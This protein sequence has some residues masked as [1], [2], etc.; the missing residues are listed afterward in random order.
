MNKDSWM[1]RLRAF[2][3]RNNLSNPR[4]WTGGVW[5]AVA[6]VALLVFVAVV[7]GPAAEPASATVSQASAADTIK[8]ASQRGFV[9]TGVFTLSG[10]EAYKEKQIEEGLS[11]DPPVSFR[12]EKAKD[13]VTVTMTG[14]RNIAYQGTFRPRSGEKIDFEVNGPPLGVRLSNTSASV[15]KHDMLT[16]VFTEQVDIYSLEENMTIAPRTAYTL[17]YDLNKVY[18]EPDVEWIATDNY[19]IKIDAAYVSKAGKEFAETQVLTFKVPAPRTTT[20]P[21]T[22]GGSGSG[23]S[24][25]T[26]TAPPK[27]QVSLQGTDNFVL[28][29]QTP[30]SMHFTASGLKKDMPVLVETYRMESLEKYRTQG[31]VYLDSDIRLAEMEK[32]DTNAFFVKNG[33]TSFEVPSFGEGA[34][35]LSATY[36]L[37]GTDEEVEVRT[38]YLVTPMTVYMQSSARDTV[39][40]LNRSGES[41]PLA[42]Y[43]VTFDGGAEPV[44]VTDADGVL[45]V[46]LKVEGEG[47]EPDKT[48]PP[49]SSFTIRDPEGTLVYYDDA[50]LSR[51]YYHNE[52]YYSYLFLDRTIYKPEDTVSFWGF[53]QP[54]RNNETELPESVT[55]V[56]D[57]GG[58][59]LRVEAEL[60][61]SGVYHGEIAL[62]RIKS[63][64]YAI[65]AELHFPPLV[66]GEAGTRHVLETEYVS[67]K[68]FEK[69]TFVLSSRTDKDFYGPDDTVTVTVNASFYDG[70]PLPF[71]PLEVMYHDLYN[72]TQVDIKDIVTD[73]SGK[74]TFRFPAVAGGAS[75]YEEKSPRTGQYM[76][77][78]ASDGEQVST[79]GAYTHFPSDT[80]VETSIERQ[81]DGRNLEMTVRAYKLNMQSPQ[82]RA[83]FASNPSYYYYGLDNRRLLEIARGEPVDVSLNMG[84]HW[85]Y[86][87]ARKIRHRNTQGSQSLDYIQFEN[88]YSL[89]TGAADPGFK[90]IEDWETNQKRITVETRDGVAVVR[91]LIYLP[92]GG[93]IDF[94]QDVRMY[95][96]LSY[97]DGKENRCEQSLYYPRD[98]YWDYYG[99]AYRE[100]EEPRVIKG[101]SFTIV[102][103]ATGE[104]ITPSADYYR[105]VTMAAG[106]QYSF[107]LLKDG[108]PVE[109]EGRIL[110]T[111]LNDGVYR[112]GVAAGDSFQLPYEVSFGRNARMVA[113]YFDG[114]KPHYIRQ[115]DLEA[116]EASLGVEIEVTPDKDSYRPGDPVNLAVRATDAV[117]NGV[118]GNLCVAVVDESIFALSEQYID[119]LY[120]LYSEIQGIDNSVRQYCST[121]RDEPYVDDN[122]WDGGKGGGDGVE[123][124]DSYRSNF[125]D[126][127]LFLPTTTDA[128]GNGRIQFTLPDN[129]TSWRITAVEVAGD[130][131]A[132]YSKSNIISTLPFFCK[133]VM[134]SKYIEGD[135]ISM[136][137]QGHGTLLEEG[138]DISYT[139]T[140][141]GDGVEETLS[142]D[143]K[144]FEAME[145]NFGK[146][147][148][149]EYTVVARAQYSGYS[150]TVEL[151]LSVIKSNLELVISKTV[152]VAP[153][154]DLSAA[155]YPVTL[156]L[157]DESNEAFFTSINSLM[158]HYCMQANQRM[159]RFVAKRVVRQTVEGG[160]RLPSYIAEGNDY[161]SD[162]QNTDGGIAFYPGDASEPLVT[163][164]VVAIA[165]D[166]FNLKSMAAY[167]RRQLENTSLS[168]KQRAACWLGLAIIEDAT[169]QELLKL[170]EEAKS[171]DDKA[172]LIAGL[173]YLGE[174]EQALALYNEHLAPVMKKMNSSGSTEEKDRDLAAIWIASSL[175]NETDADALSVYFGKASWRYRTLF[176]C[177][178]YVTNYNR[179]VT[180][181]SFTYTVKG[182]SRTVNLGVTGMQTL[183]LNK[184]EMDTLQFSGYTQG[185]RAAAYY[186]GEPT[187][188][189]LEQSENMEISKS[190]RPVS[191]NTYEVTVA[192]H[193]KEN[194]PLGDYDVNDWVPSNAR[195]YGHDDTHTSGGETVYFD[196]TEEGQ[197]L[198]VSFYNGVQKDRTIQ[199]KYR[200]RQTYQSEAVLDTT[201]MIHG[202]SGENCNTEKGVFEPTPTGERVPP[203]KAE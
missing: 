65:Q 91:D 165:K 61:P 103:T 44:G 164:Y 169:P 137:V 115:L 163:T 70:T 69:P 93:E 47:E 174:T 125:K 39:V 7:D 145:F 56:F 170:L 150:D 11:F 97:K 88:S 53:V 146:L 50:E 180:P 112:H 78:I 105:Y 45:K 187:E 41:A 110:Y 129:T 198:Y 152:D 73:S 89:D 85:S 157:Y 158:G 36:K 147:P 144:A 75:L 185:L 123:F 90:V 159:S 77:R 120:S 149:G 33:E 76:V 160:G 131:R 59:D 143:A 82:L 113:V 193:L 136:L 15:G 119:V 176:E 42:G 141:T 16:L 203:V 2:A 98:T 132:G 133:P 192:I 79:V 71:Y 19:Q 48:I 104:D 26:A 124:Y 188:I 107:R 134:T 34:Y 8:V 29:M 153:R 196:V 81:Q 40:W 74:A 9:N 130:L 13:A 18:I 173:A 28:D 51:D 197:K 154:L 186:V 99:D 83:Y 142:V 31:R 128:G 10:L 3:R 126:T 182:V 60:A 168:D 6:V 17:S 151:P 183:V 35:F 175:L 63:T 46:P 201:Y 54:F 25:S 179:M 1:D 67:V 117:G 181:S 20:K 135:D 155:R 32:L 68:E 118:A 194:A 140:L 43:S 27:P 94:E 23:S 38:S 199:F 189:G 111:I 21:S 190:V 127:A 116:S 161:A 121:Y 191:D 30:M 84:L 22:S 24:G 87:D 156:T 100:T 95:A 166:Q 5:A 178:I 58:L 80:L 162:M 102:N 72:Y 4:K 108:K 101:Y 172:Y 109:T 55:V 167:Y 148:I 86:T 195:L 49:P 122:M 177:M 171:V 96:T 184:S 62:E 52:R 66:E 139:V 106:Q 114:E 14:H 200:I 92:E 202:D 37:P 64:Q 12:V 57:D 138:S